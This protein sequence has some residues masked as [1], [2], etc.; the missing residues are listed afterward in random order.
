[1][2]TYAPKPKT[3]DITVVPEGDTTVKLGGPPLRFSVTLVNNGPD[4]AKAGLVVSLGHCSCGPPG[5]SMMAEGTMHMLDRQTNEWVDVPYVR[6]GTGMDYITQNLVPPFPLRH[7]QTVTYQLEMALNA[8]QGATITDGETSIGATLTNAD[9]PM[10]GEPFG[11][12]SYHPIT[13]E[14]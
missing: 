7:G 11:M 8:E 2:S 6:E 10:E 1:M 3:V 9:N 5:A 4:I 12:G 14:A 13:V